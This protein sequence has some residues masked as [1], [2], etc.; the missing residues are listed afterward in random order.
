[1]RH[2]DD[3]LSENRIY[4]VDIGVVVGMAKDF[5]FAPLHLDIEP[6]ALML[7][8]DRPNWLSIKINP[9]DV[10]ET[11]AFIERTWK[12]HSQ[13]GNFSYVF[14]DDRLDRMYRTEEKLGKTFSIYTFVALFVACLGLFGLAS[15]TTAQQTKE[16]GIRKVL[17]ATEWNITALTTKRFAGLVMA[18]NAVGWPVAYFAMQKWLQN[19]AYKTSMKLWIFALT[20]GMSLGIAFLTVGYQ[21]V[22]AALA[23]PAESL[24]YE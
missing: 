19:F 2:K 5:H 13:E 10:P 23:D 3:L 18:A 6:L 4:C 21:S 22:K 1:M 16:I 24:R 8:S 7:L 17:G 12:A 20:A 15:F 11:L 9:H 14:L